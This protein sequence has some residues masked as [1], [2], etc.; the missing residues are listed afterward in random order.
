MPYLFSYGTFQDVIVQQKLFGRKV[1]MYPAI[2]KN[3]VISV[4]NDGY[5]QAIKKNDST[6]KGSIL[7][8]SDNELLIADLWEEVPHLY[9]RHLY[10]FHIDTHT[11]RAWMY[12][13]GSVPGDSILKDHGFCSLSTEALE[14]ELEN[15]LLINND[16]VSTLRK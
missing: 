4:G 14:S 10:V 15:F 1:K 6:I 2:L 9:Q 13:R 11:Q 5:Y 12:N 7:S 8:L 3:H 16:K